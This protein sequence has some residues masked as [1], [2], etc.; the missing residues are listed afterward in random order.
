MQTKQLKFFVRFFGVGSFG[1]L[2]TFY[3]LILLRVH[4]WRADHRNFRILIPK[5]F[6]LC[7][8]VL[9]C[10]TVLCVVVV[11]VLLLSVELTLSHALL[12]ADS[13]SVDGAVLAQGHRQRRGIRLWLHFF[14][15][16]EWLWKLVHLLILCVLW[17]CHIDVFVGLRYDV[18]QVQKG[19]SPGWLLAICN[20]VDAQHLMLLVESIYFLFPSFFGLFPLFEFEL[21]I[22]VFV[23]K[24]ID[25][26]FHF[27]DL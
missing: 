5:Y 15:L 22:E 23:F 7:R 25:F 17:G 24:V 8:R 12:H 2:L 10:H 6:G 27:L 21:Q 9:S 1:S 19:L 18:I 26:Q 20:C 3:F 11:G 14:L 16:G 13:V 4:S